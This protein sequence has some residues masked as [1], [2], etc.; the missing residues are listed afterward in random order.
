MSNS[1]EGDILF[2]MLEITLPIVGVIA[3]LTLILLMMRH[4]TNKL[5]PNTDEDSEQGTIELSSMRKSNS[6]KSEPTLIHPKKL[7]RIRSNSRKAED[8]F[9]D[10]Q[11]GGV[12]AWRLA[13]EK[14][15]QPQRSPNVRTEDRYPRANTGGFIGLDMEQPCQARQSSSIYS[16]SMD[17]V[18]L[19]P[20]RNTGSWESR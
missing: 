15:P 7:S 13:M 2:M 9:P 1:P 5:Y 11:N 8:R 4:I 18:T 19:Y 3:F 10:T 17:G 20:E 14:P 6:V 12:F 16:R